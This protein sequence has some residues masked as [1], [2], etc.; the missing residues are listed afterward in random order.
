MHAVYDRFTDEEAEREAE[1]QR[2]VLGEPELRMRAV[3][4]FVETI[5]F[6]R[7]RSPSASAGPPTTPT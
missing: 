2:L 5:G 4:M 7:A 1:R 6:L 3:S